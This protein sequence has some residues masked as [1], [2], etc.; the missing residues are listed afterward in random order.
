MTNALLRMT[1]A[2]LRMTN[3]ALRMTR[4][5]RFFAMEAS[6]LGPLSDGE[7][8]ISQARADPEV[9]RCAQDDNASLR[10]ALL[11]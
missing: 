3:S 7:G 5:V 1:N 10:Y 2:A 11:W 4:I 6:P 9:L 8:M